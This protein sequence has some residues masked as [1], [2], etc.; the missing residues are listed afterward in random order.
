LTDG[1]FKRRSLKEER[2]V[3]Q[4]KLLEENDINV[5]INSEFQKGLKNILYM[6][7]QSL[8]SFPSLVS[9]TNPIKERICLILCI[10]NPGFYLDKAVN[11]NPR[12]R[13]LLLSHL[14]ICGADTTGGWAMVIS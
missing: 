9:G 7:Y 11:N 4:K 6:F 13:F 8:V 3:R 10:N 5:G 1:K 14:L 2:G 12:V